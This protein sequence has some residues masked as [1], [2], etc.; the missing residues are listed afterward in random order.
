MK[1]H[2]ALVKLRKLGK[3]PNTFVFLE[4]WPLTDKTGLDWASPGKQ[5]GQ[6]WGMDTPTI[7]IHGDDLNGLDLRFLV[8]LMV[9]CSSPSESRAKALLNACVKAGAVYVVASHVDVNSKQPT[10]AE[11]YGTF[12]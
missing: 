8:G 11:I 10:W 6:K 7:S 1:G 3:K 5:F 12:G 9:L 4:D 2:E